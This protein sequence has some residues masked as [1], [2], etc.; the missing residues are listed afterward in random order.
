MRNHNF[1]NTFLLLLHIMHCD[2]RGCGSTAR[3]PDQRDNMGIIYLNYSI[4]SWLRNVKRLLHFQWIFFQNFLLLKKFQSFNFS[5]PICNQK[6]CEIWWQK[7]II[8]FQS[9][10]TKGVEMQESFPPW[11]LTSPYLRRHSFL[12]RLTGS[13]QC[14]YWWQCPMHTKVMTKNSN[15]YNVQ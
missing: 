9:I 3:E 1:S 12:W 8:L 7:M 4:S 6:K 11:P 14:S 5:V 2:R 15:R 13:V 10:L